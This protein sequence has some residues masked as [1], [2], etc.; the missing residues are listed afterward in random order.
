MH[1]QTLTE[2]AYTLDTYLA[3]IVRAGFSVRAMGPWESEINLFPDAEDCFKAQA[4]CST[5]YTQLA[6]F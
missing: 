2:H 6:H 1:K 4:S 3:A 5:T